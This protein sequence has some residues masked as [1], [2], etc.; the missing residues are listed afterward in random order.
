MSPAGASPNRVTPI[1]AVLDR[2][3]LAEEIDTH[4]HPHLADGGTS[5]DKVT[6]STQAHDDISRYDHGR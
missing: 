4:G 6:E 1:T 2:P 5:C 3:I